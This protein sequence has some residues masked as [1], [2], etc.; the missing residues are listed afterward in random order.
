MNKVSSKNQLIKFSRMT[1]FNVTRE[2]WMK[3]QYNN[4]AFFKQLKLNF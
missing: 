1:S 2:D 3:G 4:F